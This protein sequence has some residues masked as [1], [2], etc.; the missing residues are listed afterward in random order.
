MTENAR[1]LDHER[2]VNQA[3]ELDKVFCQILQ[4]LASYATS[5]AAACTDAIFNL[6]S[7]YIDKPAFDA[8][9]DF[10]NLYFDNQNLDSDK[11]A[12][13][14]EVDD[15]VA[16]AQEAL[17][18]GEDLSTTSSIVEDEEAKNR[19]LGLA[20]VQKR[21]EGLITVDAGLKEQVLPAL[22]SMQFQDAISQRMDHLVLGWNEIIAADSNEV[23]AVARRLAEKCSSV[24]ETSEYYKIVLQEDPPAETADRSVFFEF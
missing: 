17:A 21:M 1:N 8:L 13:N 24:E 2:D 15:I 16:M 5:S 14:S 7:N 3:A 19:R 23:E 20:G 22:S 9:N 11:D 12:I 10:H 18:K 6:S 4:G